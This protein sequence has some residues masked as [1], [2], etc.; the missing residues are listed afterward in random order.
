MLEQMQQHLPECDNCQHIIDLGCGNGIL[1]II[2]RRLQPQAHISFVD[3]S[4][5]AIDSAK[6]NH[7]QNILHDGKT[8]ASFHVNNCL[9]GW[10]H[11]ADLILCN[12]PFH[13][14][15]SMGDQIAWQMFKQSKEQLNKGG[16]LWIVGN[17]HL[18][19]HSK[20]KHLFGH[21]QT[22]GSN[23]KFTVLKA[24]SPS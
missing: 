20:L 23:K 3:E 7:K 18:G 24:V 8:D 21:C 1:G 12:P 9:Q 13:Q 2:A 6:M 11:K 22:L 16:E 17:R 14:A 4:Y 15:H 5:M 10:Q 19:Y